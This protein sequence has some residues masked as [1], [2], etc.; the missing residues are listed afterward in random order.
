PGLIEK[1]KITVTGEVGR[2]LPQNPPGLSWPTAC[3][4]LGPSPALVG[5]DLA[6]SGV[7]GLVVEKND[8]NCTD[9]AGVMMTTLTRFNTLPPVENES[10]HNLFVKNDF[11]VSGSGSH[12][13]LGSETSHNSFIGSKGL[14]LD[15]VQDE[16]TN[17]RFE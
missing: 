12:V 13:V 15:E 1:N 17:N 9:A 7:T 8:L 3:L 10:S 11:N 4:L 14:E 6:G 5:P 2:G 16:G